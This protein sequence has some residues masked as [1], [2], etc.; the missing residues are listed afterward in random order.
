MGGTSHLL[1]LLRYGALWLDSGHI[2][3]LPGK[4]RSMVYG[5]RLYSRHVDLDV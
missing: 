4:E 1:A 3:R 5:W 2:A